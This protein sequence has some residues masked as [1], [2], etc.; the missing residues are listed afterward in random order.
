MIHGV[1]CDPNSSEPSRLNALDVS[2]A[3]KDFFTASTRADLINRHNEYAAKGDEQRH[4]ASLQF[5]ERLG[6]LRLL[7]ESERHGVFFRASERLW[8]VHNGMNNFYNEPPFAERLLEISSQ[9]A[10]P[11][12]AQEYYVHT[13]VC[14]YIGNGYGVSWAAAPSYEKMIRAFSPR[15]V[16]TMVQLAQNESNVLGRRVAHDRSCRDRFV[17]ALGLIDASSIPGAVRAAY[18]RFIGASRS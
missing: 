8:N 5:F 9:G 2:I 15:G 18:D 13:V 11:E 3:L 1:Y 4:A 16:A 7:N 17:Q 12:T 10:V 6:A 14:C